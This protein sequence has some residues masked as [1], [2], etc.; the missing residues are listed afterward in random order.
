MSWIDSTSSSPAGVVAGADAVAGASSSSAESASPSSISSSSRVSSRSSTVPSLFSGRGIVLP[1]IRQTSVPADERRTGEIHSREAAVQSGSG[2]K[3]KGKVR[4]QE[5][6]GAA[7]PGRRVLYSASWVLHAS[8][9]E[10]VGAA[11]MIRGGAAMSN[12]QVSGRVHVPPQA[13]GQDGPD[14]LEPLDLQWVDI[15]GGEVGMLTGLQAPLLVLLMREPGAPEGEDADRLLAAEPL[16]GIVVRLESRHANQRI[17][18]GDRGVRTGPDFHTAKDEVAERV[19]AA[20]T[21]RPERL[22]VQATPRAPAGVERWLDA[23]PQAEH[24]R[25]LDHLPIRHLEV[26]DAVAPSPEVPPLPRVK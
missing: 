14:A 6:F 4:T 13:D 12:A 15:V 23:D 24:R 18:R 21:P 7:A 17:D 3:A 10:A 9:A 25:P 2:P 8:P 5:T 16:A 22:L 20:G 26:L 1:R 11:G 19:H